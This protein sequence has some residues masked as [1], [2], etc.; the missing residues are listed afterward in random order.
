[1]KNKA[2]LKISLASFN[3]LISSISLFDFLEFKNLKPLITLSLVIFFI[4][5]INERENIFFFSRTLILG[6]IGYFPIAIKVIQGS[7]AYWSPYEL[8]TQNLR[9]TLLMYVLTSFALLSSTIGLIMG[10]RNSSRPIRNYKDNRALWK[11]IYFISIPI[12]FSTSYLFTKSFGDNIFVAGYGSS[13][14]MKESSLGVLNSL[15]ITSLY[16]ILLSGLK[17]NFRY[18]RVVFFISFFLFVVYAQILHGGRQDAIT[19]IL[20]V[21]I[22]YGLFKQNTSSV[23]LIYL[24][25]IAIL[26]IFFEA[27]GFLRSN[28]SD[29]GVDVFID[30]I[31]NMFSGETAK[32]GTISPIST[33]FANVVWLIESNSINYLLGQ[34][35]YEYFLRT[36]PQFLYPN[37]PIDYAWMFDKFDLQT[38]GGFFELAEAYLNFGFFGA[39]LVPGLISYLMAKSYSNAFRTQSLLSYLILFTFLSAFLRGTWYQTFAFY[40][41]FL[42]CMIVYF[43]VKAI[44]ISL[45]FNKL[46]I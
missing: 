2:L 6:L 19:P 40:K 11:I 25:I 27:W 13:E 24:P 7:D 28:I 15:G 45:R 21:Y 39:L 1:M 44:Y 20:G 9:I 38:V 17:F 5:C 23:K 31:P 16:L 36:P 4:L 30:L 10:S 43:F 41:T 35:Y 42:V 33:T 26:Y 32:F 34:S 46:K 8:S 22:I 29:F 37:R 14:N 18:W 3:V 12:V